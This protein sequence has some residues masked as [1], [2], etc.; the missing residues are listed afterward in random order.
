MAIG[1][2]RGRRSTD[3]RS[4]RRSGGVSATYVVAVFALLVGARAALPGDLAV[5]FPELTGIR[6]RR[7]G[8]PPRLGGWCLGVACVSGI[9]L[10]RTVWL[11]PAA[12][13]DP[14]LLLHEFRHVEQWR[15]DTL[16]PLRYILE[17]L[18]RGYRA[19][20]YEI[21]A[22]EYAARRLTGGGAAGPP[23]AKDS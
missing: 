23:L 9:T 18:T 1:S 3:G 11:S 22:R 5:R 4:P 12:P 19:N 14:A 16:F 13:W 20:R 17:S 7:G 8:L 10:R 21:D 15:S 6:W 2:W